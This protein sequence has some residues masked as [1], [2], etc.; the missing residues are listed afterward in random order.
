MP[1]FKFSDHQKYELLPVVE[2]TNIEP[3]TVP[4]NRNFSFTLWIAIC[5]LF[6]FTLAGTG[7]YA[8]CTTI[9]RANTSSDGQLALYSATCADPYFR[10]EW[11]SLS[12]HEKS[13]YLKA[14]TCLAS[15]TSVLRDNGTIYDDFP[16]AHNQAAHHSE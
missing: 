6:L 15:T 12:E 13:S 10:R 5:R 16:W 11:R 9:F 2:N 8:L 3:K 4:R 7:F 14:V 1:F